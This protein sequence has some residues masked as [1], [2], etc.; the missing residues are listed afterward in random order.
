MLSEDIG[1]Y[2]LQPSARWLTVDEDR[3]LL[4][5]SF[6]QEGQS[7]RVS[8]TALGMGSGNGQ[9]GVGNDERLPSDVDGFLDFDTLDGGGLTGLKAWEG[10][11][12]VFK[13]SQVHQM[14]RS[15]SRIRAYLPDTL[16]RRHGA[17]PFS[18]VEGT[19]AEGLSCL[20]FLDPEVGPMQLGFK[21][22]RVLAPFL[23]RTWRQDINLATVPTQAVSVTY[24]AEKRQVWWHVSTGTATYQNLRWM[25]SVESDGVVFHTLPAQVKSA[26]AWQR[27]PTLLYDATPTFVTLIGQGDQPGTVVDYTDAFRYRA[28]VVTKAYQLGALLRRFQVGAAVLEAGRPDGRDRVH[29]LPPGFRA[30]DPECARLADAG[31][32]GRSAGGPG[33]QQLHERGDHAAVRD[34]RPGAARDGRR[35][36]VADPRI[37]ARLV[38]RIADD[39]AGLMHLGLLRRE[40]LESGDARLVG[41]ATAEQF[42]RT[43]AGIG[44]WREVEHTDD[45]HHGAIHAES[46][47]LAGDALI[48]G[49]LAVAGAVSTALGLSSGAPVALGV[50]QDEPFDATALRRVGAADVRA[51]PPPRW[52]WSR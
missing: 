36:R 17:I 52:Q 51:R 7:A 15:S 3:L 8:W 24:H 10:K 6:D 19:D 4:G 38:P 21:G 28:Y 20:Y 26:T 13:R 41:R 5:G 37:D 45:G 18:I 11:V 35:G 27:K 22:L 34:R 23:Q 46:L 32:A 12:I 31:D 14:V 25:Y 43:H 9:V 39:G 49:D 33:G 1:D 30:R 42:Q 2:T 44:A 47:D 48:H 40:H 16:S 50:W 29:R